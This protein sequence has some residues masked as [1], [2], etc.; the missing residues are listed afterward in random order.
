VKEFVLKR[1][2]SNGF[3]LKLKGLNIDYASHLKFPSVEVSAN[4]DENEL[5][6]SLIVLKIGRPF[7]SRFFYLSTKESQIIPRRSLG[8]LLKVEIFQKIIND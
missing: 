4:G 7:L 5:Y 8:R 2:F 3:Q 6:I 1:Y